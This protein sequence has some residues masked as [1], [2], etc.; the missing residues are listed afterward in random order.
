MKKFAVCIKTLKVFMRQNAFTT[1]TLY[2]G[3]PVLMKS[4]ILQIFH[5]KQLTSLK[6][7]FL[8]AL[9]LRR[10]YNFSTLCKWN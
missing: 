3:A 7:N 8:G 4:E 6:T 9:L 2:K 1:S 10:K 5:L